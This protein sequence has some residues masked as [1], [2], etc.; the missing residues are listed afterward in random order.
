MP[1]SQLLQIRLDRPNLLLQFGDQFA[2]LLHHLRR[3]PLDEA[4]LPSFACVAA[5]CFCLLR[6]LLLEPLISLA[7]SIRPTSET[8]ASNSRLHVLAG[9]LRLRRVRPAIERAD[10]GELPMNGSSA[11]NSAATSS[12]AAHAHRHSVFGSTL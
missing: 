4:A 2:L 12:R 10:A 11:R 5:R 8:Y 7:T 9:L 6:E 1:L 3:R